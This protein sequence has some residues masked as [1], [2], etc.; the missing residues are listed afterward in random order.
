MYTLIISS[1]VLTLFIMNLIGLSNKNQ[2]RLIYSVFFFSLI[3]SLLSIYEVIY[4]NSFCLVE[5]TTWFKLGV[6]NVKWSFFFDKLSTFLL[7]LIIFISLLV[8]FF[9]LDYLNEDPHLPRFLMLLTF[10]TIF[11]ELLVTSGN[12]IQFFFGWEGV[13][14]MS[15]LLINFW[16]TRY[17]ATNSGLMAIIY[18]R[19]GDSGLLLGI[20]LICFVLETTDFISLFVMTQFLGQ[21]QIQ[22]FS[23][24]FYF[25]DVLVVFLFL[26]VIGKSAQIFLESWLASAMEGPTP[27]SSLLHAST[28]IVSGV[29]LLQ[30]FQSYVLSSL[31]GLIIISFVGALTAFFAGTVGLVAVDLKRIIAYSTCSQMGYLVFCVGIGN[32]NV[33]LFHLFNH[34]FFKC[35]LFVAAGTII[36]ALM[37]EQDLRN[38]GGLFKLL[39]FPFIL[40]LIASFSLMGLPFL[41]GYY[42][43]EKILEY[44]F[45][46]YNNSNFF[47]FWLG[48]FSAFLTSIYSMRLIFLGFFNYPNNFKGYYQKMHTNLKSYLNIVLLLL[49][50]GSIF[51]G[52]I[53]EDLIIGLGSD[54]LL[55]TSNNLNVYNI[56][57][58]FG[59]LYLN[60]VAFYYTCLGIFISF[61]VSYYYKEFNLF[62]LSIY[63]KTNKFFS[64]SFFKYLYLFL[65]KRWFL[66]L[67][68][69][70]YG[71]SV[72]FFL[73]YSETFLL[74]DKG[75]FEGISLLSVRSLSLLANNFSV[76]FYRSFYFGEFL[77]YF[78][79]TYIYFFCFIYLDLVYFLSFFYS[80]FDFKFNE[81]T[82][83]YFF[84]FFAVPRKKRRTTFSKRLMKPLKR[85]IM[86]GA[87]L[88][89]KKKESIK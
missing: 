56:N 74:L 9:A 80:S 4:L 82:N 40:I 88:I 50:F 68:Y 78:F 25:L 33:S 21:V 54:W 53:F 2:I 84:F 81:L 65:G 12:I 72:V 86:H 34:A 83:K 71:A 32:T 7:L 77:L 41:S 59:Q 13:G 37:N 44:S 66:N 1:K 69:N 14:L 75:F 15:Y 18:N 31:F 38:M 42:S 36:H 70:R 63:L 23:S 76:K 24:Y 73:G 17:G 48:S 5:L 39:P 30:R 64:I 85:V 55:F 3:L 62:F 20:T 16:F 79:L 8:H 87:F 11:M 51:S 26:G 22:I 46:I 19:V 60:F 57:L 49:G 47:A 35:L 52:F 89:L 43:K 58:H 10:F 29:F 61:I 45:Y 28:M 67:A 27:V 6:L